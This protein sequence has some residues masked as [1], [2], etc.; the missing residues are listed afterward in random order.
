MR[1]DPSTETT[2]PAFALLLLL[3]CGDVLLILIHL[4]S[5]ETG[6]LRGAAVH[7]ESEGGPPELYQ[8]LK[9][10]WI[11]VCL[12]VTFAATRH[13]VYFSWSLIFLFLL[14]DDAARV[15]ENVGTWLAARYNLPAPFGL[16]S[17]DIG[18]LLFAAA[19]GL[20]CVAMIGASLWR[21]TEQSYRVSRDLGL[22]VVCLGVLGV[23]VDMLHVIAYTGRSLLAQVLLVIEDGGEMIVMS[24]V[25]AYAFHVAM[26]VGRSRFDLWSTIRMRLARA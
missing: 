9:E 14:V 22:L 13:I 1:P 15:H 11:A 8:Y 4:I 24:A 25:M 16:R 19:A 17:K 2:L 26:H 18:E 10:F 21:G 20:T 6:W 5:V 12:M 7:L 3:L 23:L